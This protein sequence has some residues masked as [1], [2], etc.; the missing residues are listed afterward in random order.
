VLNSLDVD[1][2]GFITYA[3]FAR[4]IRKKFD[5]WITENEAIEVC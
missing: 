4:G 3:E 1:S 2:R 5:V